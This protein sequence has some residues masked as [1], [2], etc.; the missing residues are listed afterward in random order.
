MRLKMGEP[1][2]NIA[3]AYG[4]D[5]DTIKQLA[6][7]SIVL[8]ACRPSHAR[9]MRSGFFVT[10]G[11]A[12]NGQLFIRRVLTNRDAHNSLSDVGPP[13]G[14]SCREAAN[15]PCSTIGV[16]R[17]RCGNRCKEIL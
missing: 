12:F 13:S 1:Q 2:A 5:V 11:R 6:R 9:T 17:V 8:W 10:S 3:R 7:Y 15:R 16:D 14:R 4:V